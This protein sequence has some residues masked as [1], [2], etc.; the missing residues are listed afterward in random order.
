MEKRY[1]FQKVGKTHT[2]SI[3]IKCL[4][5]LPCLK[6]C[7]LPSDLKWIRGLAD[8]QYLIHPHHID[9]NNSDTLGEINKINP[10]VENAIS[11]DIA[12]KGSAVAELLD[13]QRGGS[14]AQDI[15][16]LLLVASL[17]NIQNAVLGLTQAEVMAYICAPGR[18]STK[19]PEM[20]D[21]LET[22]VCWYLHRGQDGRIFFKKTQNLV[23][24]LR[25]RAESYGREASLEK[26]KI[27]LTKIFNQQQKDC[28][29][30]IQVF[31]AV[32]EIQVVSDKVKLILFEPYA[33][34]L[35]P[36]LEAFYNDLDYKNRVLFLSGQRD[37]LDSLIVVGK[38][39][40]AIQSIIEEMD[41][42]GVRSDDP[43]RTIAM[44][45]KDKITFR[46]L[47]SAKETF[48]TLTYPQGDRLFTADFMMNYQ[49]N[50]Y[51]G[52]EQIR[53]V[54]KNKQ[55]FTEDV[56]NDTFRKK[57]EQRL[58]TRQVMPWSEIKNRAAINTAWQWHHPA[59]LD[60]LKDEMVRKDQWRVDG[61]YV[62]KGPFPEPTTDVQFRELHRND[63]TGEVALKITPVHGN[64]VYYEI[65][66]E[67]T[68]ASPRVEELN[69]FMT[70]ETKI[71][72]LCV[73]STGQHDTGEPKIWNNVVTLKKREY[74]NAGNKIV[75]L[76]SAPEGAVIR[77]TT[78]GSDPRTNGIV[79]E[80]PFEVHNLPK[81]V[82]AIAENN[83][84]F[85]ERLKFKLDKIIEFLPPS[86]PV[87]WKCEHQQSTTKESFELIDRLKKYD[88][89][90]IGPRIAVVGDTWLDLTIGDKLFLS[91][92]QIE[93]MINAMRSV[94][95]EGQVS[96]EV[97]LL[98]FPTGQH[99]IDFADDEKKVIDWNDVKQSMLMVEV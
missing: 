8:S 17:A 10:N 11:H 56:S 6:Y 1:P 32:D 33:G 19:L 88:G 44:E 79:Y 57:C 28:Y 71:S 65:G 70:C 72:F 84:I 68:P 16:K 93:A 98:W 89:K 5:R 23:A 55:K 37:T 29:Q 67:A 75:E 4:S 49:N 21:T 77:Y 74:G 60:S 9:L 66:S 24:K 80:N 36:D 62:D 20:M 30:D 92:D 12:S 78:D 7:Q 85:S 51:C 63:D 99:L 61:H 59:A 42:E 90:L 25:S 81:I 97:L 27:F 94:Y 41:A 95:S 40:K 86:G 53:E 64:T 35:H 87:I 58:F 91:S 2:Q 43:Q 26:L 15:C 31:P 39:C 22:Q 82:I 73:D 50:K 38:E 69:A 54:L 76:K 13:Y 14:D 52:E 34:K 46:L 48:T 3:Q 96:I 83:G 45:L 18:D 47:S